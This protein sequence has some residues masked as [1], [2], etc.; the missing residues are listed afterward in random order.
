MDRDT[1]CAL[2][3][4]ADSQCY[5]LTKQGVQ[6]SQGEP[7]TAGEQTQPCERAVEDEKGHGR[8]RED[9]EIR[10]VYVSCPIHLH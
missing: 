6:W 5:L 9:E 4:C 8:G 1:I 7:G 2:C 3:Q 10:A